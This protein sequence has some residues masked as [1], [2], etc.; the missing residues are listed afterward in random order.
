MATLGTYWHRARLLL[1]PVAVIFIAAG[2]IARA[3][4]RRA[5]FNY[6]MHCQGCHLPD[7]MGFQGKVPRMKDF[8][9]YFLHSQEGREFLLRVPGVSTSLLADD[10]LTELMNWLIRTHSAEQVPADFSPFTVVEVATLRRN[11]ETDPEVTRKQILRRIAEE[12]PALAIELAA[13]SE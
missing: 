13:E 11:P 9:G 7:A 5:Q 1:L 6:T 8:V 3:D 4:D 2:S 12:L 10:Q